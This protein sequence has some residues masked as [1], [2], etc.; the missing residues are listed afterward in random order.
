MTNDL[1]VYCLSPMFSE[2]C[3]FLYFYILS[4]LFSFWNK[5]P[6]HSHSPLFKYLAPPN[7]ISTNLIRDLKPSL[8]LYQLFTFVHNMRYCVTFLGTRSSKLWLV[9]FIYLVLHVVCLNC[10]F[11]HST[12]HCVPKLFSSIIT[13]PSQ[14]INPLPAISLLSY[15]LS[16]SLLGCRVPCIVIINFVVLLSKL[17]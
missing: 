13:H 3:T 2:T 16:T 9:C 11:L 17:F 7:P 10:L 4:H 14:L 8:I 1:W 15:T 12:Q 6:P 5:F